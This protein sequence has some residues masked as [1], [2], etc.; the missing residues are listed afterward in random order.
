V[1]P[2]EGA[3]PIEFS[4]NLIPFN[5]GTTSCSHANDITV[6]AGSFG[7]REDVGFEKASEFARDKRIPRLYIA[8][9]SGARI[10]L[11]IGVKETYKPAFLRTPLNPRM[12]LIYFLWKNTCTNSYLERYLK[13][14]A[15]QQ[16][17]KGD[18]SS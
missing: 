15:H 10:G 7:T 2:E 14:S 12:A 17:T 9:N 1:L 5:E 11:A 18:T 3:K 4:T 6:K 13:P 16:P 8:A